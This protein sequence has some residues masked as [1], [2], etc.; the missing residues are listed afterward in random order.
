MRSFRFDKVE[1]VINFF[2]KFKNSHVLLY[3]LYTYN[4]FSPETFAPKKSVMI[5]CAWDEEDVDV[6]YLLSKD[7]IEIEFITKEEMRI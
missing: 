4:M 7:I 2:A 1:E 3:Q 6:S 5:R